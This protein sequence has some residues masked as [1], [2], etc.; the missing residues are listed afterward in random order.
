MITSQ[1]ADVKPLASATSEVAA[2]AWDGDHGGEHKPGSLWA[3][4]EFV[5]DQASPAATWAAIRGS[6]WIAP[7]N[8]EPKLAGTTW[9]F[10]PGWG[11]WIIHPL[12]R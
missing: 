7:A 8:C 4:G 5:R 2:V 9:T 11:A 3:A 6:T 10:M 1:Y 12:P